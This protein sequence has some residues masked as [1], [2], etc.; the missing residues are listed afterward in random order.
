[1]IVDGIPSDRN[2][3]TSDSF[4]AIWTHLLIFMHKR[5]TILVEKRRR[6]SDIFGR[7]QLKIWGKLQQTKV[8]WG[9]QTSDKI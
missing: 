4:L 8:V 5:D 3:F 6:E 1:M 9:E 2:R 7:V